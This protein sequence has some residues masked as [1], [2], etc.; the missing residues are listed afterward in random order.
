MSQVQY[1]ASGSEVSKVESDIAQTVNLADTVV[2][3]IREPIVLLYQNISKKK[4]LHASLGIWKDEALDDAGQCRIPVLLEEGLEAHL[5]QTDGVIECLA[6]EPTS[7]PQERQ[8]FRLSWGN[9]NNLRK[10][11]KSPSLPPGMACWAYFLHSLGIRPGMSVVG[12]R[13]LT[14]GLISTQN[15]GV[16]MEIDGSALC[17][18]INLYSISPQPDRRRRRVLRLLP[19]QSVPKSHTFSFGKLGWDTIN[20]QLHAHFTPGVE[21]KLNAAKQP[22]G[23][24]GS[25]L[26]P[27]T[28]MASYLSTLEY[29]ASDQ[30]FHL[31]S[32]QDPLHKRIA[33]LT[34]CL[35]ELR[36]KSHGLLY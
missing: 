18:L 1:E 26:E 2:N 25:L 5:V 17:H 13:P 15:G 9:N 21:T 34:R 32:P 10:S 8:K 3:L 6:K 14:D 31:P 28:I 29:G 7:G 23:E 12:W 19:N 16:E 33:S 4:A 20:D 36:T 27:G 11:G 22:F 30:Q 35:R 24:Q